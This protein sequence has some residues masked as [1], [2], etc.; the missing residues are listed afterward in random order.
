MAK[1]KKGLINVEG[2]VGDTVIV[3]KGRY[4]SYIRKTVAA[5]TKKGEPG[6]KQQYSRTKYLN[7]LASDINTVVKAHCEA[8]KSSKFY[9]QVQSH[10]RKEPHNDR[11]LLL[12]T[13]KDME[14]NPVYPFHRHGTAAIECR[15]DR[16][17]LTVDL[18]ISSHPSPGKYKA[19]CYSYEVFCATWLR[20]EGTAA[21]CE[22]QYSEW[23]SIKQGLP[24]FSF[25]FERPAKAI[26]WLC[27]VRI[28]LGKDEEPIPSFEGD[29]MVL[30]DAGAF[31][32][33]ET[34]RVA[35]LTAVKPGKKA[36]KAKAAAPV[37]NRV[38]ARLIQGKG[39]G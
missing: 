23:V 25:Y 9:E 31:E 32:Q 6:L 8:F 3:R 18:T 7:Q 33:A 2:K 38:K 34:D 36:A 27:G 24:F 28:R 10:F 12:Y 14:A 22:R 16:K 39:R 13:L 37:I 5:G 11:L 4:G 15:A 21:D 29:G 30:V 17:G 19:D 20:K 26:H 35:V 1:V